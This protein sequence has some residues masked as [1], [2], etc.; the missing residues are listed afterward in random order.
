MFVVSDMALGVL[1]RF[2]SGFFRVL[3]RVTA[4]PMLIS[5]AAG[6]PGTVHK[7]KK[8]VQTDPDHEP[9][10]KYVICPSCYTLYKCFS[11]SPPGDKIPRKCSKVL[12]PNHPQ[13]SRRLPCGATLKVHLSGGKTIHTVINQ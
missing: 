8:Y 5:L 3:A 4:S 9:F 11:V 13:H 7:L 10:V 12:F 1:L 6:I 2:V